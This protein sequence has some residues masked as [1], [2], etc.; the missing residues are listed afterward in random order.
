MSALTFLIELIE[1]VLVA[2]AQSGE[3]NSA[4]SLSFI[5]GS[6]VRGAVI[7]QYGALDAAAKTAQDLFFNGTVRYLNAYPAHAGD[8]K[9]ML[10][11]PLSWLVEKDDADNHEATIY[12]FAVKR[13][14]WEQPA[15]P[16]S[17]EFYWQGETSVKLGTP[18][19]FVGVH[20]ASTNPSRKNE[21]T[22]Q[23]FRYDALAAGQVFAG[24]IVSE[25]ETL[26]RKKIQRLLEQGALTMGRSHTAG[27]GAVR[28]TDVKPSPIWSEYAPVQLSELFKDRVTLTCLSDVI[29]RRDNGQ[30]DAMIRDLV[31]APPRE[32]FYRMRLVGGFNRQ[33]GLPLP[34]AWAIQ[35]GSVFVFDTDKRTRLEELAETGIGERRA[36]GFGCIAVNLHTRETYQQSPLEERKVKVKSMALAGDSRKLA[37]RMV[38][39]RLQTKWDRAL[40]REINTVTNNGK[41]FKG[42]PSPA[43][44]AR[45]RLAA[46]QAW[47][48]NDLTV[49]E[50]HFAGLSKL[51]QR[52]WV[53]ACIGDDSLDKW[54]LQQIRD[55]K[56][57]DLIAEKPTLGQ[58]PADAVG[59]RDKML[60]RF[61]EGV[62][63][64]ALQAAKKQHE[65]GGR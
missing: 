34:Q 30:V 50:K 51:T 20:N 44:L 29:L 24:V 10:P 28:I 35:A 18:E 40:V 31:G 33:W 21:D 26:L 61:I 54:I 49:I 47:H 16:P 60:A 41:A 65:G 45:V 5:P 58:V 6:T 56:S 55:K 42:L 8:D 52:E 15:K 38:N 1:P 9:R 62:L 37:E 11:K 7:A 17:G 12:D 27:Y 46:R 4:T 39:R 32:S 13:K 23:V 36:E 43:Q 53:G 14:T 22:S 2:Q 25:D 59:L 48:S 19:M 63:K 57:F 64:Q 3:P